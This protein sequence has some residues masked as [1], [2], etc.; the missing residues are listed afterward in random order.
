VVAVVAA[1]K[2]AL[3]TLTMTLPLLSLMIDVEREKQGN[4]ILAKLDGVNL[5]KKPKRL[6]KPLIGSFDLER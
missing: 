1:A 2:S 4:K 6:E 3:S 5:S